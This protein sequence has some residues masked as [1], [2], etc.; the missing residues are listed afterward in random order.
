MSDVLLSGGPLRLSPFETSDAL[1]DW[2]KESI[3][4]VRG[5]DEIGL[6]IF[7]VKWYFMPSL[8]DKP[9]ASE[10]RRG[11]APLDPFTPE[12]DCSE[13]TTGV[14]SPGVSRKRRLVR[15]CGTLRM[16]GRVLGL[17]AVL[18]SFSRTLAGRWDEWFE[19]R[20]LDCGLLGSTDSLPGT[21][22]A[23]GH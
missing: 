16:K 11:T 18:A 6:F 13:S 4:S 8:T 12:F 2:P 3:D 10:L 5:A 23:V 17:G 1:R 19:A 9:S 20:R 15:L 7:P 14:L 22:S 21:D